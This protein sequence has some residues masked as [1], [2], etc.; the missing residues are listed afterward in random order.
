[1]PDDTSSA[2]RLPAGCAILDLQIRGDERG[3][4]VAIEGRRDVPFPIERVYYIFGTPPGVDR[5]FHAHLRLRQLAI[6]V[7]G[8][9]TMMLDDGHERTDVRLD[10]PNRGLAIGPMIW[11]EM[12][13][14]TPD[15]VLMVL[16]DAH[17]DA[18][19][20]LRDYPRFLEIA[21]R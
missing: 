6:A 14:F 17:Y 11:R 21:R 2:A 20:Y 1:M 5:G 3:S 15:C 16:A 4:L 18:A 10:R 7:S 13:D 9:C 8:A 12:R 19:E